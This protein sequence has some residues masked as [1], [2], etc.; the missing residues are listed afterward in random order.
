MAAAM[1]SRLNE[2][3]FPKEL[4]LGIPND[5]E[6]LVRASMKRSSR[7]NCNTRVVIHMVPAMRLNEA[8]F[9]K[10]LQPPVV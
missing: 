6:I 7:R 9:P 2:A 5:K 10:E 4:Q 1:D 3:Q 8:Q